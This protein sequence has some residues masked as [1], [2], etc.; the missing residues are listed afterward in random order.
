MVTHLPLFS[1]SECAAFWSSIQSLETYWTHRHDFLPSYTLGAAAYL[2]VPR[3]GLATY[4]VRAIRVNRFLRRDFGALLERVAQRL[5]QHL[6]APT[7][8]TSRFA[9]PGFH[10]FKH[11]PRLGELK[12][13]IHFDLQGFELDFDAADA[14]DPEKRISFT[15]PICIPKAGAGLDVWPIHYDSTEH[16]TNA[17]AGEAFAS[18]QR[19]YHAYRLGELLIHDGSHLHAIAAGH[20]VAP[21]DLR[22]TLQGHGQF[23]QGAWQLYW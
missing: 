13:S 3:H 2:D 22:V 8:I 10:I 15:V 21:H 11:H 16:Q 17:Q 1:P 5:S 19:T 4:M 18:V 23:T 20:E 7:Q 6:G 9:V 14:A 12:P